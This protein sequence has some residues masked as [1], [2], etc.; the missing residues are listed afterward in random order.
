MAQDKSSFWQSIFVRLLIPLIA[1]LIFVSFWLQS[2][3]LGT[4]ED[5][6]EKHMHEKMDWMTS[7]VFEICSRNLNDFLLIT[8]G[9]YLNHAI[10]RARTLNEIEDYF[11]SHHL[12]GIIV[13]Q[14]KVVL[15]H[16]LPVDDHVLI[17][18]TRELSSIAIIPL[19]E[20]E[21]ITKNISFEPWQWDIIVLQD[22]SYYESMLSHVRNFYRGVVGVL[23]AGVVFIMLLVMVNVS[24]PLS[25]I[26]RKIKDEKPPDYNGVAEF[27]YLSG[28][29]DRMMKS[30]RSKNEFIS[31]LFD[32]L[33]AVVVVVDKHGRISMVNNYLCIL[34]GYKREEIVGRM[35]WDILPRRKSRII[36]QLFQ[37]HARGSTVNGEAMS[38]VTK[39][40]VKIEVLWHSRHIQDK[41]SNL[42]WIIYTGSDVSKLKHIERALEKERMLIYSLFESSP[43]AQMVV[44]RDG[45]ILD[46]NEKFVQLTGY[47]INEL[48]KLD[49][50]LAAIISNRIN[51]NELV[52]DWHNAVAGSRVARQV[53][54]KDKLGNLKKLEFSFYLLPDGRLISFLVDMTEKDLQEEENRRM[55]RELNQARKMEAM[56][57]LAGGVAHDFNNILQAISVQAQA[58]DSRTSDRDGLKKPL[59]RI[60]ALVSRGI[61][62]IKRILTFS[63]KVAPELSVLDINELI[64]QEIG[65]LRHALPKMVEMRSDLKPGIS[66]VRID[67]HQVELVLMNMVNNARDAIKDS[68]E[69]IVSTTELD[70]EVGSLEYKNV[71]PGRY[72]ALSIA[73]TGEGMDQAVKERIFDPFYTTKEIGRGTGLGL[74]TVFGIIK[75]HGGHIF[76]KST[77]GKG[78]EFTILLPAHESASANEELSEVKNKDEVTSL[79]GRESLLIV[80][81]ED[82]IR[83]VT[84]EMF[85]S[86]GYKVM[87][88]ASGE[89]AIKIFESEKVDFILMDLGM[90]GMGGEKCA[91]LILEMDSKAKIIIAS[92][93]M[94]HPMAKNPKKFGLVDFIAKPFQVKVVLE[95]IRAVFD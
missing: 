77:P 89:E 28:A 73:D 9:A 85:E 25:L 51:L 79:S 24:R 49:T 55:E 30:I 76:C 91:R 18:K 46:V 61:S 21:Y 13:S 84:M 58:L 36:K 74:P 56:G 10:V 48:I 17:S 87:G 95:K 40:K 94:D 7:N 3:V 52:S 4:V 83:E 92:G 42:E 47:E 27:S 1:G 8:S 67:K 63:R 93:Y 29:I 86:Y 12:S 2:M 59:Q 33:S 90:P 22:K 50:W 68:G 15:A 78:T 44:D 23:S 70:V 38:I 57:V 60:D 45:K 75:S 88:A 26:I 71:T 65:L 43:L 6:L 72:I 64:E 41:E 16:D 81:D 32:A 62:I 39:D 82:D 31:S 54:I 69:I 53:Q 35:I 19:A 11:D 34:S 5:F 80:D 20:S 14:E 37:G 66:N